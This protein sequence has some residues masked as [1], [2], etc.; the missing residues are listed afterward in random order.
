MSADNRKEPTRG[1]Y[2]FA[3]FLSVFLFGLYHGEKVEPENLVAFLEGL[4]S[5]TSIVF[6]VVAAWI[7]LVYPDELKAKISDT[8]DGE[9]KSARLF[10]AFYVSSA[11][12]LIA[13]LLPLAI[14]VC[15]AL[16]TSTSGRL[17]F[18]LSL[19]ATALQIWALKL[20]VFATEHLRFES[21]TLRQKIAT[22]RRVTGR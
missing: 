18:A 1:V 8:Q 12:L 5:S 13:M 4:K 19:T 14:L 22:A 10:K 3:L 20:V 21:A 11:A 7:A 9:L 15:Q 17:G 2:K 6:G 16:G